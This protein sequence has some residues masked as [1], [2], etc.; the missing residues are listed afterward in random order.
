MC[1]IG[2]NFQLEE[3]KFIR[4]GAFWIA[5]FV[6]SCLLALMV[7]KLVLPLVPEMHGGHGLM[8]NDATLFHNAAVEISS[9]IRAHGWSEWA[10]FPT[11][12]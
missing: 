8:A 3:P 12:S 2:S 10:M 5:A 9:R 11:S 4:P 6:Y 7:Q 1:K